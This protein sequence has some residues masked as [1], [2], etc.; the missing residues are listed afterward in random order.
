MWRC[1][2]FMGE[3]TTISITYRRFQLMEDYVTLAKI[4]NESYT[5]DKRS[6]V[7][8]WARDKELNT[9]ATAQRWV[10]EVD[11]VILGVSGYETFG[12]EFYQPH[13]YVGYV[14]VHPVLR[15][16]GV[17]NELYKRLM[18]DLLEREPQAVFVW[19]RA[20]YSDGKKLLNKNGFAE[21]F[22]LQHGRLNVVS[23]NRDEFLR[24]EKRL[25]RE[26]YSFQVFEFRDD[27]ERK[28]AEFYQLYCA[29][30]TAV[31][32]IMPWQNPDYEDFIEQIR[33]SSANT[34]RYYVALQKGE[35]VGICILRRR[36]NDENEYYTELLG[37]KDSHRWRGVGIGLSV[38]A[39]S[40]VKE[41]DC[42]V[43]S[44]DNFLD[45]RGI[46]PVLRQLGF[47]SEPDWILYK[48]E[49]PQV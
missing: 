36:D 34:V 26:G 18:C 25:A 40:G 16:L 17:G 27:E 46:L 4:W 19:T 42:Q 13:N 10:A 38:A 6:K 14:T 3:T 5:N 7:E 22:R 24:Y 11:G 8:W 29:L 9:D 39:I 20:D 28:C 33:D 35:F 45:N 49:F 32:A 43:I 41:L 48:R 12:A 15:N 2:N 23:F 31:P 37:V 44:Q 47:I 1:P 30:K 21:V